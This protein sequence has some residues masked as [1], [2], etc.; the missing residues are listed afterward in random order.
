MWKSRSKS[1][2]PVVISTAEQVARY[3]YLVE[4]LPAS[5][6]FKAHAAAFSGLSTDQRT[7]LLKLLRPLMPEADRAAVA[8]EPETLA[9]IV[10]AAEPRD[11]MMRTELAADIAYRFLHSPPVAAYFTDGAGSVSIDQQPPWVSELAHHESA[12][13]DA[14]NTNPQAGI[15]F[16]LTGW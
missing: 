4:I 8:E 1:Q 2:H 14:G 10:G 7:E 6:S 16:K 11:T 9:M 15:D 3:D 13:I 12:P 5:L